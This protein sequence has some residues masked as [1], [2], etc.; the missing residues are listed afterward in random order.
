MITNV[1]RCT[2]EFISRIVMAKAVFQK[3]EESFDY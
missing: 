2:S 3:E 1:A